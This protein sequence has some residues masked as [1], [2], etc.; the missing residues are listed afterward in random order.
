[1]ETSKPETEISRLKN[2]QVSME[3]SKPETEITRL[4]NNQ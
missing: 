2:N 3:T 4:K 1:M